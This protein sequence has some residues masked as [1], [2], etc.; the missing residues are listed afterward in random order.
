LLET[1]YLW[2]KHPLFIK[3]S[4]SAWSTV[5]VAVPIFWS[6]YKDDSKKSLGGM[7]PES[8][9]TILGRKTKELACRSEYRLDLAA[10]NLPNF[11]AHRVSSFFKIL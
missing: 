2:Q 9:A 1:E 10:G 11:N 6:S 8:T 7:Q 4:Y 5:M 3:P